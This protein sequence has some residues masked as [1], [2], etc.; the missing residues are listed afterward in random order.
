MV[1]RRYATR[2]IVPPLIPALKGRAEVRGRYAAQ[3]RHLAGGPHAGKMP[4]LPGKIYAEKLQCRDV[5]CTRI[6]C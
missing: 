6:A 2:I 1:R 4:A 3:K 5:P